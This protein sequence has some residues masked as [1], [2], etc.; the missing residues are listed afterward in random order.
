V[1]RSREAESLKQLPKLDGVVW[2]GAEQEN[3]LEPALNG[4]LR[5]R[6]RVSNRGRSRDSLLASAR[7]GRIARAASAACLDKR[8][9]SLFAI[10]SLADICDSKSGIL[11]RNR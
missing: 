3:Q 9:L 11:R 7:V 6:E 8:R 2:H 10:F 5:H 4:L 1:N